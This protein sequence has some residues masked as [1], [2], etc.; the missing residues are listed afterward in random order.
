M[1]IEQVAELTNE[2]SKEMLGDEAPQT[3][4]LSNIVDIGRQ[5]ENLDDWHNKVMRSLV[6]RIGRVMLV[7]RVYDGDV[8]SLYMDSWEFGSILMKYNMDMYD[9]QDNPSWELQ[10]GVNYAQ[11]VFSNNS[12]RSKVW[13]SK[14][15]HEVKQSI[16]DY[17]LK[18]SFRSGSEMAAFIS[19]LQN[20][21]RNTL[22][23]K[24]QGLIYAVVANLM[25]EILASGQATQ[26]YN[27]L[28]MYNTQFGKSL[29]VSNALFD[30]D[31]MR[32]SIMIMDRVAAR[33]RNYS[34]LFNCGQRQRFTPR[35]RL[36]CIMHA[37]FKAAVGVYLYNAESQFNTDFLSLP[38]AEIMPYW[39][40]SGTGYD[41]M[42]TSNIKLVT[43][44]G[45][46]VDQAGILAIMFDTWAA[47]VCNFDARTDTHYNARA[48]FTNY[49]HKR[50]AS[51]F[52]D[53][54]ENAVIFFIANS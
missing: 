3:S 32:Y 9:A 28:A 5:I 19:M 29:T 36:H 8:P 46:S 7:D 6:N 21:V 27:L 25:G 37:D 38:S 23:F 52:N 45:S 15:T 49:W 4:D 26:K 16:P 11:D 33:M 40:G 12:A 50:S 39:Q 47:G 41:F 24:N 51:Y 42:D 1:K 18:D 54:D 20:H 31:F 43:G 48:N 34:T 22:N 2:L 10:D 13:N 44:S 30:K 35:D 14:T 53:T 17:Q